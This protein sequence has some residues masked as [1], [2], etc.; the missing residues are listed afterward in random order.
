[1]G[2]RQKAIARAMQNREGSDGARPEQPKDYGPDR[3]QQSGH[4]C[5]N[6]RMHHP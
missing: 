6:Q 2:D 3:M 5:G 1:L 4:T